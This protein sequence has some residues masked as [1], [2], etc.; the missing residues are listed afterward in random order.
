MKGRFAMEDGGVQ[1]EA[2]LILP[3]VVLLVAFLI[4]TALSVYEDVRGTAMRHEA[5]AH[6]L[7]EGG[8]PAPE[9]LLRA[10]FFLEE[11]R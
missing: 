5:A 10:A 11:D 2:A 6:S 9:Q 8:E 3:L 1:V 4:S 7:A